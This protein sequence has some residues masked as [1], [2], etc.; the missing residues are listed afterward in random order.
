MFL[1]G[2][3]FPF[4]KS[5]LGEGLIQKYLDH[6]KDVMASANEAQKNVLN[7]DVRLA[8]FELQRRQAQRDLQIKE[9]EHP[10]LWWPKFLIMLSVALYVL[11]R[12]TVK[13]WGLADYHIAISDLDTWEAG[14]ASIVMAYMF[15]GGEIKRMIGK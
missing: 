3:I 7:A 5:F 15:L 12:F 10:W 4:V 11:A 9:M 1:L 2:L 14:V 6:K 13:T 8:E